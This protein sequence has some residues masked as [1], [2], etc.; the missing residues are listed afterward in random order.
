MRIL[1]VCY[2][3]P[4]DRSYGAGLR[5]NQIWRAL[6]RVGEVSALVVQQASRTELDSTP[7]EGEIGRIRF[8]KPALPWTTPGTLH[9]RRLV[10]QATAGSRFDLVV[11]RYLRLAMLLEGCL[12]AP[13]IVDGDDL[14]KRAP[15]LG[16]AAVG[17]LVD[18]ARHLARRAV[19]RQALR[20]PAHVWFVHPGDATI[21]RT[22]SGSVLPNVVEVPAG[23]DAA[24]VAAPARVLMVGKFGYAPNAEGAAYFIAE[25]WPLLRAAMPDLELR[26]VG[27]CPAELAQRWNATE[28]VRSTGFVDDLGAQYRAVSVVVAPVFSG[29]GTQ[30]KVLE[31]L[32]HARA[33]VVSPF[34]LAGFAP[35]LQDGR[36]LLVARTAREWA[37]QCL[38]LIRRPDEATAL[39]QA[40]RQVVLDRYSFDGMAG[41]VASTV[42]ALVKAR[43]Q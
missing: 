15:S 23:I 35:H 20:R 3:S 31:A 37:D 5:T 10:R 40:G 32:G 17:R 1:L 22:V 11:V 38:R 6:Q 8:R 29:G 34:A 42:H 28:G 9:I 25:V 33:T 4:L 36:H 7:R 12:D 43:R 18:A 14:D 39:A 19:T 30:I 21:F 26:L 13:V 24:I 41:H 16:R 2:D 27:Q